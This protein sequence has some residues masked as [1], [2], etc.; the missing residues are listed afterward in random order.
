MAYVA[1]ITLLL[2]IQ[3]NYF[4][5]QVGKARGAADLKAPA[6]TGDDYF[7]RCVRVHMN[8]LEQL[9]IV[10]PAMWIC[11]HVFRADVAAILGAVFLISRF[12]FSAAYRKEP[13]S[14]STGFMIG[15]V[16]STAMVLCALY[17]VVMR[18]V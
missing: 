8:T 9:I 16:A 18:L 7:E 17:G 5:I 3:Y 10:L 12:I 11:A 15:F 1:L 6:M 2:L 14:R 4:A 13:S